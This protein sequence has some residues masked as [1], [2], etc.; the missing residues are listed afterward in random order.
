MGPVATTRPKLSR[1]NATLTGAILFASAACAAAAADDAVLPA[2]CARHFP[3]ML[4]STTEGA[5]APSRAELVFTVIDGGGLGNKLSGLVSA[6]LLAAL[7]NR[8]LRLCD[9]AEVFSRDLGVR[10]VLG[11]A[12][13]GCATRGPRHQRVT[14]VSPPGATGPRT[15]VRGDAAAAAAAAAAATGD[16][17]T[18]PKTRLIFLLSRSRLLRE[19][20]LNPQAPPTSDARRCAG[21]RTTRSSR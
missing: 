16:D 20:P 8:T 13:G 14:S 21:T 11:A 5:L 19:S 1:Q 9:P 3:W 12:Y 4:V 7:G 18:T 17:S 15:R 10:P 6:L 2:Q